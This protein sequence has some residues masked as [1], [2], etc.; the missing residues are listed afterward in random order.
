MLYSMV[1]VVKAE[2]CVVAKF[3]LHCLKADLE[4]GGDVKMLLHVSAQDLIDA[5]RTH[6][7]DCLCPCPDELQVSSHYKSE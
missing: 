7:Q 4:S 6:M 2:L 5:N 3:V 1:R